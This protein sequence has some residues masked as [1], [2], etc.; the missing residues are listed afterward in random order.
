MSDKVTLPA[1]TTVKVG[2]TAYRLTK[3]AAVEMLA[4]E[5]KKS[6][7]YLLKAT[8]EAGC[9]YTVRVT[10]KWA[11]KALPACPCCSDH[12]TGFVVPLALELPASDGRGVDV[13]IDA[14]AFHGEGA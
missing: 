4:A 1:T 2:R 8:C 9:G 14:D 6:K 10:A 7:T 12:K 5:I 11:F 3:Q 13:E